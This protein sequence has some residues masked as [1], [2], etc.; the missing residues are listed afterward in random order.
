MFIYSSKLS[1]SI[2]MH[3]WHSPMEY[4]PAYESE[5]QQHDT[6]LTD[7]STMKWCMKWII[8]ELRIWNQVRLWSSQL[9]TQILQLRK[10]ARKI[11]DFNGV[12]SRYQCLNFSG[13]F[14][15]LQKLR[16]W[17]TGFISQLVRASYRYRE[18]TSSNPVEV[19]NFS[20]FFTQLQKLRS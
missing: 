9:W 2:T 8:Y 1:I 13:F 18:V 3:P 16:S 7:E 5:K 20:G 4:I 12:T 10:E 6:K 17:L 11:Q 14:T 15:Q 19:L